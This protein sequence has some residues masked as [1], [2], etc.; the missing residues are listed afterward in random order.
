MTISMLLKTF[1]ELRKTG[2]NIFW[3]VNS[4]SCNKLFNGGLKRQINWSSKYKSS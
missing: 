2:E 3:L 4:F 1:D